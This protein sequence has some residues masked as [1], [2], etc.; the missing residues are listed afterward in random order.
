MPDESAADVGSVWQSWNPA[1]YTGCQSGRISECISMVIQM[2]HHMDIH[3]IHVDIH[4]DINLVIKNG[5]VW[6]CLWLSKTDN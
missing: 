5:Y 1:G 4:V 2:D 3:H 6:I